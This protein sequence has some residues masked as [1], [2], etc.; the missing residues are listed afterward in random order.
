MSANVLYDDLRFWAECFVAS[1]LVLTSFGSYNSGYAVRFAHPHPNGLRI[2]AKRYTEII[3]EVRIFINTK[4]FPALKLRLSSLKGRKDTLKEF[5][6]AIKMAQYSEKL[7]K[8]EFYVILLVSR[9]FL[10]YQSTLR[11]LSQ[12]SLQLL[13]L[14][15]L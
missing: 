8:I 5:E 10:L 12:L 14:L 1:L 11:W 9:L 4:K 7:F 3:K 15:P 6:P 13:L 2:L